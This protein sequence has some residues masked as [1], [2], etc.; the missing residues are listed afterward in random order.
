[1]LF[2][3]PGFSGATSGFGSGQFRDAGTGKLVQLP[4]A[5]GT[6]RG[7]CLIGSAVQCVDALGAVFSA[8]ASLSITVYNSNASYAPHPVR[9]GT[10]ITYGDTTYIYCWDASLASG[11]G[12]GCFGGQGALAAN[13]LKL[14]DSVSDPGLGLPSTSFSGN[15]TMVLDPLVPDCGWIG[16]HSQ[17]TLR[18]IGRAHV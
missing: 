18:K 13:T 10:R 1:M 4:A 6:I 15:Y 17:P 14:S 9:V 5:D 7:V 3:S 8:P 11:A 2:R 16:M 12:A